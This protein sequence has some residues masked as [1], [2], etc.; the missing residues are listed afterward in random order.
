[1]DTLF[2]K[3]T[4]KAKKEPEKQN[5]EEYKPK[6]ER[7]LSF[8]VVFIGEGYS[9]AKTSFVDRYVRNKID[10]PGETTMAPRFI[11]KCTVSRGK[12]VKLEIWDTDGQIRHI[13]I[14]SS[15]FLRNAASVVVLYDV[16]LKGSLEWLREYYIDP[17]KNAC[18]DAVVMVIG[19][20]VDLVF[21][22]ESMRKVSAEEGEE[23]AREFGTNLFF[24]GKQ[25]NILRLYLFIL[26]CSLSKDWIQR[27]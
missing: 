24:E 22:D 16:T 23:L 12:E 10:D 20:K 27:Q 21:D 17:I 9:A 14:V 25:T 3:F 26:F 2:G 6:E 7:P 15:M 19:N 8:R 1:M 13:P 5:D 11:T 4:R 18:P